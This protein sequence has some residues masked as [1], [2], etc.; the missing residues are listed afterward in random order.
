M[1]R[2]WIFYPLVALAALGLTL[3]SFGP[4]PFR[5]SPEAQAG[6]RQ[7]GALV[8]TPDALA[9]TSPGA[10]ATS[11]IYNGWSP[12]ALRVATAAGGTSP[13]DDI[14]KVAHL[15]I[16]AA[17]AAPLSGRPLVVE[18]LARPIPLAT[19]PELLV[20]VEG[21]DGA[22]WAKTAI[23]GEPALVTL[24]FPASAAPVTAIALYPVNPSKDR[25]LGVEIGEIRI[26][27]Q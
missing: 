6:V 11:V 9:R 16:S 22:R 27:A 26:R 23:G 2:D 21:A 17:A 5:P 25:T 3:V 15:Q 7:E 1:F 14:S 10:A 24:K 20:G 12:F 18:I 8:F 4:Y 13:T 19:A